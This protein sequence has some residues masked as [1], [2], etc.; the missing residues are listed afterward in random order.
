MKYVC[1]HGHFYQ[2]PR[3]NPWTGKIDIQPSASPFSNWNF[4]IANEC[5]IPNARAKILDD[6]GDIV[7]RVSNYDRMSYNF[8]PT[9][10]RWFDENI[11]VLSKALVLSDKDSIARYG[12]GTAMAQ[13]FHHSILPLA[14]REDKRTEIC[15]GIID[16]EQR[17]Q[18]KPE[19]MWLAETAVDTETLEILAEQGIL[20][21]ILAPRQAKAIAPL[22]NIGHMKKN[23]TKNST[24][25][26][27]EVHEHSIDTSVPYLCVLPSGRSIA[28]YFYQPD[29]SMEIAF[30]GA[31]HNGEQFAHRIKDMTQHIGENG[32]LHCATD[33]ESYGHHHK[34]GEMALAYCFTT[35]D[36]LEDISL[37]N[38]ATH[39]A[40][41]PP[42]QQVQIHE[43]SSWSCYHG[44]GRWSANCGCVIDPAM[45]NRQEWRTHLRTA[46]NVLRDETRVLF[47]EAMQKYKI[48]YWNLRDI[49]ILAKTPE[50]Q[51]SLIGS[52]CQRPMQQTEIDE[53]R[54]WM[55]QQRLALM[56]FTSCGWFFDTASG[57][58]PVQILRYAKKM[59]EMLGE[60]NRV[61]SEKIETITTCFTRE[62]YAISFVENG[63]YS[64]EDIWTQLV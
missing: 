15:W 44:V 61:S 45:H 25:A 5:Y 28:L 29:L 48:L 4:R 22:Q 56:M 59:L 21:T 11:P 23:T 1:I 42:T 50:E 19:G 38:Y 27:Q 64:G 53:I 34:S 26:W 58:E 6:K 9:L 60:N 39:L 2:P 35:L 31:L 46:L 63:K 36:H 14:N 16:F 8:G 18:R 3:E 13:A 49:W 43:A 55:E 57:L 51:A 7:Q 33:G 32:L 12:H 10:L 54:F 47:E 17:F 62:L 30:R 52:M 20:F 24:I 41:Y 37:I 40:L